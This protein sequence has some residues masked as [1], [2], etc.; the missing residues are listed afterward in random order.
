[1][2]HAARRIQPFDII[3]N[4]R[5]I[6]LIAE[7]GFGIVYFVRDVNSNLP[8]AMKV[9]R[10]PLQRAQ[11][12][13]ELSVLKSVRGS[14]NFPRLYHSG[15][16]G[17]SLYIVME[18]LGP[19]LNR[20]RSVLPTKKF[21][22]ACSLR[23]GIEMVFILREFHSRGFVHCDVKPSNFL[24]RPESPTPISL[25]DFGFSK[26]FI[27]PETGNPH[28]P[29][30]HT[31]FV[32]TARYASINSHRKLDL[33][34]R[35]DMI[36]WFF[37]MIELIT[38]ELP[39]R[40]AT[41]RDAVLRAK[42]SVRPE[43]LCAAVPAQFIAIYD[44]L[45]RLAYEDRPDYDMILTLLTEA[46][47]TSNAAQG[48]EQYDWELL[49]EQTM[50][51]IAVRTPRRA[52]DASEPPRADAPEA[53]TRGRPLLEGAPANIVLEVDKLEQPCCGRCLVC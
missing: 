40:L 8:A 30:C 36:S 37:T 38:G 29:S 5:V 31:C 47:P 21:T 18:L 10:G 7:S 41:D 32:G 24:I 13:V 15:R 45:Q 23:V 6:K 52:S 17:N 9:D 43:E 12:E 14:S 49:D 26:R 2:N 28:S 48:T 19:S 25:I 44:S 11:M 20:I 50:S 35:D 22:L 53:V 1:M 3:D 16:I 4:Y 33:S 34:P 39:W 46:M 42:E 27:D 51:T